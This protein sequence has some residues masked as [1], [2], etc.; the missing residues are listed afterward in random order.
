VVHAR[1][2]LGLGHIGPPEFL[3]DPLLFGDVASD[4]WED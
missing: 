4:L 2:E 1:E 3:L